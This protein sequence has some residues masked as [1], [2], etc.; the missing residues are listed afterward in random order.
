LTTTATT[1]TRPY[2]HKR[3]SGKEAE[4]DY[5]KNGVEMDATDSTPKNM[6]DDHGVDEARPQSGYG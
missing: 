5:L 1:D 6:S 2:T 3:V 4:H